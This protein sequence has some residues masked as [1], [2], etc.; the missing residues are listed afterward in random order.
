MPVILRKG[1][2][3]PNIVISDQL[4]F[5][6]VIN[7]LNRFESE[8]FKMLLPERSPLVS[9][10]ILIVKDLASTLTFRS[11]APKTFM[12]VPVVLMHNDPES[13]QRGFTRGVFSYLNKR[14]L[15]YLQQF[16]KDFYKGGWK[17]IPRAYGELDDLPIFIEPVYDYK[18][19][20]T[21]AP[22]IP[23]KIEDHLSEMRRKSQAFES[24][25]FG[26]AFFK[27]LKEA[28]NEGKN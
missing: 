24:K 21:Y 18:R 9:E 26:P 12:G 25:E 14:S 11:L 20:P 23:P 2:S 4:F 27:R 6:E 8:P 13:I 15:I 7:C 1:D 17:A 22:K 10:E 19:D 28:K 5:D 3:E 16:Y